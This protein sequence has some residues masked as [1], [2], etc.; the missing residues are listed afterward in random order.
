MN[1]K[2]LEK[3]VISYLR[4]GKLVIAFRKIFRKNNY[5]PQKK[6]KPKNYLKLQNSSFFLINCLKEKINLLKKYS[7]NNLSVLDMCCASGRHLDAL[8]QIFRNEIDYC[9]FEIN[10]TNELYTEKFFPE[11]FLNSSIE[12]CDI[13]E[14]YFKNKRKFSI[15]FTH[16]RS[17]DLV[18]PNFDLIKSICDC[19]EYYVILT[20][21]SNKASTSYSRFWDHE[22]DRNGFKLEKHLEPESAYCKI[23]EEQ[24]DRHLFSKIYSRKKTIIS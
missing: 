2:L 18:N 12:Y 20:N 4:F 24:E 8:Q 1:F 11:L 10:Q 23:P 6:H 7:I 14:F 16:G 13:K 17:I 19:T 15:S 3:I 9:G 5:V 21:L 22:F